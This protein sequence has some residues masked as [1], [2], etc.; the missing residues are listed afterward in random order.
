M[1]VGNV[2]TPQQA[3]LHTVTLLDRKGNKHVIKAFQIDNICG[4]ISA[5]DMKQFLHLC[6][7]LKLKEFSR[8]SGEI[9]LLVGNC[10]A[11]L[12]P[13]RIDTNEGLV[14]CETEF[15]KGRILG[16]SHINI[17]GSGNDEN[18]LIGAV[19]YCASVNM[20]NLRVAKQDAGID[21]V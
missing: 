15:G 14:L 18:E 1:L 20:V 11:P 7:G 12:H 4:E 9:E 10:Y 16:G 5:P 2:V 17:D 3:K 6:P 19:R 21:C 13:H 8:T